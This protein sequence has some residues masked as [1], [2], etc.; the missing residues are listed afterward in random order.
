MKKHFLIGLLA[1]LLISAPLSGCS[2]SN[3]A[4]N[5]SSVS[6]TT[7]DTEKISNITAYVNLNNNSTEITGDSTGISIDGNKISILAGGTYSFSGT[8][9]DGQI[10][11]DTESS[12]NVYIVL[13]GVNLSCSNNSPIYIKNANKTVIGLADNTK[14][15][16][17][18]AESY[19]FED[20]SD[21]PNA[22]IYSKDDL[23]FIGNGSLEVN[24]NYDKGINGK[25]D[26][27]I[28]NGNITVNSKGDAI[29]GKDSLTITN[30]N[31]TINSGADGLKSNN[32]TDKEKG[33]VYIKGGTI[34]IISAEDGIQGENIVTVDSAD[35]NITS[36]G[37]SKNANSHTEEMPPGGFGNMMNQ[38]NN[39]DMT[40]GNDTN[41]PPAPPQSNNSSDKTTT[42]EET[43][44]TKGIKAGSEITINSGNITIDSCDD[45]VHSNNNLTINGGTI[46]ISSG[47]DGLHADTTLN[48]NNGNINILTSYEGIES[49]TINLN[50]GTIHLVSSDDGINASGSSTSNAENSPAGP[51]S[52]M[53][54]S[55]GTGML[56]ING[57]YIFVDASGDGLDANGSAYMTGGTVLVCGP[58][59]G[60]N[61]ALDY[62]NKFEI[63]G[64]TLIAAGSSGMAQSFSDTSTQNFVSINLSSQPA[65]TIVNIQD[66]AGNNIITFAPS[67]TFEALTISSPD[68]KNGETYTVYTGG[69]MS[70]DSKDGLYSNDGTYSNG[71][72][73][74]SFTISSVNNSVVQDGVTVNTRGPGGGR[75]MGGRKGMMNMNNN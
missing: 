11:V 19:T 50:D 3:S 63:S 54:E 65:N 5:N 39:N 27:T 62:D 67:K 7:G 69:T 74:N 22:A 1:C 57:G 38:Q 59:N 71:T 70:S 31:I 42:D 51:G 29:R 46:E 28:E 40:P 12:Q 55:S 52:P 15:Y 44:S 45:A 37:G 17:N 8:L 25:D 53:S 26:L 10:I 58:T 75:G 14:N 33:N 60:G 68:L 18:D 13:N 6:V 61:G 30:G 34:N 23:V 35:I 36:G 32:D 24:G 73:I 66:S 9:D 47:D 49:E 48:I 20:N 21:E 16:I 43:V 72:K 2:T 56:N 41:M 64:G 4:N